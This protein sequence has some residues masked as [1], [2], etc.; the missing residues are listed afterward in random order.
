MVVT[1]VSRFNALLSAIS[2]GAAVPWFDLTIRF[3]CSLS[4]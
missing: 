4:S 2:V 3:G 1:K